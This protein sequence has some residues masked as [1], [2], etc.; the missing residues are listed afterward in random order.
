MWA[1]LGDTGCPRK[2]SPLKANSVKEASL[3]SSSGRVTRA[4]QRTHKASLTELDFKGDFFLGH[5]VSRMNPINGKMFIDL[6]IN[7]SFLGTFALV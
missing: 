4:D 7:D 6:V 5:P 2:K 1:W 3:T